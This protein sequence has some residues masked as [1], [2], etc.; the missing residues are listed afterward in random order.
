M[1]G[2]Q[3][4]YVTF[5]R[6]SPQRLWDRHGKLEQPY[7]IP[8]PRLRDVSDGDIW[9]SFVETQGARIGV[10]D[11]DVPAPTLEPGESMRDRI[12]AMVRARLESDGCTIDAAWGPRE[13]LDLHQYNLFPNATVIYTGDL[14]SVTTARPGPTPDESVI[15]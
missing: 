5:I 3:F 8:S 12:T 9:S 7:G 4:V 6:T 10:V 2:S 15:A 13:L 14:L 11:L 1:A